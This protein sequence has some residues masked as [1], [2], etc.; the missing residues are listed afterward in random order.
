VLVGCFVG[1]VSSAHAAPPTL[2]YACSPP[3]QPTEASCSAWHTG[4]VTLIWGW[5][6]TTAAPI[7]GDCFPDIH[8]LVFTQDTAGTL[9]SCEVSD[10]LTSTKHGVT[11][12]IDSQSPLVTSAIPSRPPD[13]NGWWNH[14]LSYTFSGTDA[15]S[16][17]ASCSTTTLA[18]PGNE[19]TGSCTDHAGNVGTRTFT[20]PFDSTPPARPKVDTT[21]G[22]GG[23]T[24]S[25]TTAPGVV[26][27]EVERSAA[28][29]D[30][31]AGD[32][33]YS[34]TGDSFKDSSLSNGD[35]YSY[36][37]TTFDQANN[38][39][40]AA[41]SVRPDASIGLVPELGARLKRPPMLSW[42]RLKSAG[43]YNVQLY[44]GKKKL[45][46]RWPGHAHFQLTRSWTFRGEQMRLRPG[47]YRWYVWPGF[48]SRKA[49]KYGSLIGRS[50][51]RIV[52]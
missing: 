39:S 17:V 9:A 23:A 11:I 38:S 47:K 4:P 37:V 46:T 7:D 18:G 30:A 43:Y 33:V 50:S 20:V 16:K 35:T 21:A 22:N 12:Q 15:T 14:A 1:A 34:G 45:M 24:I 42:P 29:A 2:N 49:H 51:F 52:R 41:A 44:R 31:A 10:G 13:F 8:K 6:D 26:R 28:S 40:S 32:L 36:T 3:A 27:S 19:V 5:D 48:G 25:W